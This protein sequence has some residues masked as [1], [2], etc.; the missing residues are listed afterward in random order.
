MPKMTSAG[1][2]DRAP[3]GAWRARYVAPDGRRRA[4][5]FPTKADAKA[6]LSSQHADRVRGTWRD[7]DAGRTLVGE[8]AKA[9]IARPVLRESTRS[10]YSS[11]WRIH[12]AATWDAAPLSQATPRAVSAWY[13]ATAPTAGPAA[14]AQA[15]R[16]L[17][18]V[19]EQA[20]RDESL[21][22]N[23]CRAVRGGGTAKPARPT[24][25]LTLDEVY[26]VAGAVPERYRVLVLVQALGALRFGEATALRR[27]DV[28]GLVVRVE[29]SQ[30]AGVVT[31]PKTA[32]GVRNVN[33]P[34]S[35]SGALQQH[36][37]NYVP[38]DPDALIFATST[39]GFLPRSN[40][41]VMFQR[42]VKTC[43]L[44]PTRGHELRH[45]G[46][47]LAAA[48]GATTRELMA[49][50][51]HSSPNAALIYQHA[52]SERDAEIAHALEGLLQRSGPAVVP[53]G[54]K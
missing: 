20:V 45:T 21:P 38:N 52:A 30:R 26:A 34:P 14:L 32:A 49:R 51:G 31:S 40:W 10:L 25:S 36:L 22:S 46:A 11:T 24:R 41:S 15:F 3:S 54:E 47:T 7:P 37:D 43:G 35:I 8:Y 50:L 12:L 4:K 19:L 42:A 16:L 9:F 6:W 1:S 39:G 29:R 23:P 13:D 18:A 2:I 5:S 48:S 33:L 27:R 28:T 53:V 44:P 17:R